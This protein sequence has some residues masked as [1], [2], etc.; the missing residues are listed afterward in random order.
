MSM[1]RACCCR[2]GPI[3]ALCDPASYLRITVGGSGSASVD[4]SVCIGCR[5]QAAGFYINQQVLAVDGVY[6]LPY[7]ELSTYRHEFITGGYLIANEYDEFIETDPPGTTCG[8]LERA[9]LAWNKLVIEV[10]VDCNTEQVKWINID[11]S[12]GDCVTTPCSESPLWVGG[13]ASKT[14]YNYEYDGSTTKSLGDAIDN[15]NVC[16]DPEH[17]GGYYASN[18]ANGGKVTAVLL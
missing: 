11:C 6:D 14:A 13:I 10:T 12:D 3:A 17:G 2:T 8:D 4:A 1:Q 5:F 7:D 18:A 15:D 16:D 9:G